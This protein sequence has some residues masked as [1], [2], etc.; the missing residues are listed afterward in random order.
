MINLYA[1]AKHLAPIPTT[2]K[3]SYSIA[4]KHFTAVLDELRKI[5]TFLEQLEKELE[6]NNAP[7]THGRWPDW[8]N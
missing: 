2:F 5:N 6:I 8:K 7:F 3:K 1:K 4:A